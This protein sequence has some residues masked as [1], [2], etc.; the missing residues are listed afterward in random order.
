MKMDSETLRSLLIDYLRAMVTSRRAHELQWR[1]CFESISRMVRERFPDYRT[2]YDVMRDEDGARLKHVIW[3]M[4]IERI[5]VPSTSNPGTLNDGWPFFSL[6]DYGKQVIEAQTP[7]PYDPDGYLNALK[8]EVT[9]INAAVLEY[10]CEGL[11]TFRS[12]NYLAA[13]V[14]LGAASEMVFNELCAAIPAVMLDS[15]ARDKLAE[16]LSKG[17]MKDRINTIVGWCRNQKSHL[18]GTWSGDEQVEDI[19]KIADL[20]RRRRNEA[21]HPEDPP[22]RPTREQMYSY[23]ML[24]PEYCKH[25]YVLRDWALANVGFIK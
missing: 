9:T 19:D 10:L 7:P 2:P 4:I 12:G 24:F 5:L 13:A 17:K 18:P 15:A 21:G 25:L 3:D 11:G 20:I 8:T 14:M 23:L 22:R 6:T 16:K 1:S